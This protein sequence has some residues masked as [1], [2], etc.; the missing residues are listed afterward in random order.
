[1]VPSS[2]PPRPPLPVPF[3]HLGTRRCCIFLFFSRA[4]R[5]LW[6]ARLLHPVF[7]LPARS[8]LLALLCRCGV[9]FVS[10][11]APPF[12]VVP[13]ALWFPPPCMHAEHLRTGL[14]SLLPSVFLSCPIALLGRGPWRSPAMPGGR[15]SLACHSFLCSPASPLFCV[16]PALLLLFSFSVC[17]LL[18]VPA[19]WLYLTRFHA[20]QGLRP[21]LRPVGRLGRPPQIPLQG[22]SP[23]V[24][25]RRPPLH[26]FPDGG[27][28]RPVQLNAGHR[29]GVFLCEAMCTFAPLLAPCI[30]LCLSFLGALSDFNFGFFFPGA[31]L[32]ALFA[33]HARPACAPCSSPCHPCLAAPCPP[34]TPVSPPIRRLSTGPAC[35]CPTALSAF[36]VLSLV[37]TTR[38]LYRC[39][40]L[41]SLS[42]PLVAHLPLCFSLG[43]C[44]SPLPGCHGSLCGGG[45]VLA[46]WIVALLVDGLVTGRWDSTTA[47]S[48]TLAARVKSSSHWPPRH[49]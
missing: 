40:S 41:S 22:D 3:P 1:M 33:A 12:P 4:T 16:L 38:A 2:W 26:Q 49:S 48:L 45:G 34:P 36:A 43:P 7:P 24:L 13:P 11:F 8:G 39:P 47:M 23:V 42:R 27:A 15:P 18:V 37:C 9:L 17:C 28:G 6:S 29:Q 10:F 19:R 32:V 44:L 46:D 21:V 25:P 5:G 31:P 14:L 20:P 30:P 35:F